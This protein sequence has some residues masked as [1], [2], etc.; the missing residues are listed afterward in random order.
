MADGKKSKTNVTGRGN[1]A[2][3]PRPKSELV[4]EAYRDHRGVIRTH[5]HFEPINRDPLHSA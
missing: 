4:V 3:D 5:R 1:S 2:R